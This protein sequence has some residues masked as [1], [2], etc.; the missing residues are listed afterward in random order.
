MTSLEKK[1]HALLAALTLVVDEQLLSE[2]F[3]RKEG[4]LTFV[5]KLNSSQQEIVFAANWHPNNQRDSEIHL[6]PMLRLKMQT[7]SNLALELV[8]GDKMLLA[9][10]PKIIL[11]QPIDFAAP[12]NIRVRWFAN[13]TSELVSNCQSI[14]TFL[15]GWTLPLLSN[16]ST[17]ED[18]VRVY[19]TNDVRIMRQKHWYVFVI[20]AYQILG[21]TSDVKRVM[22]EQFESLGVRRKYAS[23]FQ[24]IG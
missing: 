17:P 7:I 16:L 23:L 4:D 11:N 12:K 9:G 22:D 1:R 8:K 10:A 14:V 18:L 24:E 20:A 19:E 3:I 6:T 15:K 13:D 5:R 21:R 2:G